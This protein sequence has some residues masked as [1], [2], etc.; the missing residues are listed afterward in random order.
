MRIYKAILKPVWTYGIMLW[1]TSSKSNIDF[2]E[3]YQSKTLRLITSAP[4]FVS[5]NCI[6]KDLNEL[7]VKDEIQRFSEK[8]L[9]RLS[10]HINPLAVALLDDSTRNLKTQKSTFI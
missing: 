3:R 8:Y 6:R 4:W 1:G 9:Q 2:L 5:N 7:S 10:D